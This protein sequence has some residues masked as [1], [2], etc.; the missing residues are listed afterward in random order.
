MRERYGPWLMLT[1]CFIVLFVV[2][3]YPLG[4]SLWISLNAYHP[5]N[6]SFPQGFILFENYVTAFFDERARHALGVTAL[7]TFS[8]VSLSLVLGMGIALLFNIRLPGVAIARALILIPML[9]TPIAVGITWRIMYNPELGVINYL[10][11]LVG[12]PG[13]GW[14]GSMNQALLSVIIVDVWQWTPFMF[15]ILFAGVR[16][17]PKSPFEAAAI[18]GAARWQTFLYVTLPM[19]RPV[20]VLAVLLRAVDS[21]RTFDQIFMM[22]RGGPNLVT[23]LASVYLQRVNFKFFDIGYGAALSWA[24]LIL[25]LAAV[26]AFIRYT[27]FLRR[28]TEAG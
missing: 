17:L 12:L 16:S 4:Y 24:F 18:D 1:P 6:P 2:G 21:V 26:I 23:D 13:Q 3:I 5:T 7:F 9:V 11:R 28:A 20:I 8:S 10:L 15:L 19:M 27:G 25:L 22:T 14:L